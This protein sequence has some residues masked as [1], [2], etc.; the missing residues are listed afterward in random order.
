MGDHLESTYNSLV[1]VA[2]TPA[3]QTTLPSRLKVLHF[4]GSTKSW[5]R[6]EDLQVA[7]WEGGGWGG[8]GG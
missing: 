6:M 7:V 3:L 5:N 1:R 8:W 4:S 2:G